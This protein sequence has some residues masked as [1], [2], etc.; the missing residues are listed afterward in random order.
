MIEDY[1]E[2]YVHPVNM[3]NDI[4]NENHYFKLLTEFEIKLDKI[5]VPRCA[6]IYQNNN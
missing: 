3:T 5:Y 6:E 2:F 4:E 1:E